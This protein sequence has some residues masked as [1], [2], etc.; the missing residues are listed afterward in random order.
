M[1]APDPVEGYVLGHVTDFNGETLT[2]ELADHDP[3]K[4]FHVN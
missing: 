4:V 3:G 1:W 2:I